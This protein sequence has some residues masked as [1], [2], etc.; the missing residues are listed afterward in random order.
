MAGLAAVFSILGYG[1]AWGSGLAAAFLFPG[2]LALAVL[3][4]LG[5]DRLLI[6]SRDPR[7]PFVWVPILGVLVLTGLVFASSGA[8][9]RG[10]IL[11]ILVVLLPTLILRV[12]WVN[13]GAAV[14]LSLLLFMD[15]AIANRNVYQHPFTDAP[16]VYRQHALGLKAA[17]EQSLDGRVL[18]SA[19]PLNAG[20]TRNLGMVTALN[21]AGGAGLPLTREQGQWWRR[22]AGPEHQEIPSAQVAPEAAAP[23]LLNFMAVQVIAAGEDSPLRRT[24]WMW[25]RP[26]LRQARSADAL[27]LYAN[28][29]ALRRAHWV[30][31]WHRAPTFDAALDLLADP[32]LDHRSTAILT[33]SGAVPPELSAVPL[34]DEWT[35]PADG[36]E[37][38]CTITEDSPESVVLRVRAEAAGIVVLA[39]TDAPGWRAYLNGR[40]VPI[41]RANGLFRGVA[42]P[43]GE[44]DL[45]FVYRPA[46][47]LAGIAVGTVTLAVLLLIGLAGLVRPALGR[48]NRRL[49]G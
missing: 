45:V 42:V 18:I 1:A 40:R 26:R 3:A 12:R 36:L 4:G 6:A 2:A 16:A 23:V 11:I 30:P 47:V 33:V 32:A 39:D 24:G 37:G 14:L 13:F 21:V 9:A 46:P 41:H 19:H 8:E 35:P 38:V 20:L 25:E 15:L 44:H 17:E 34:R 49:R 22:L 5:A 28:D 27:T 29:D 7:S 31:S 48:R 10:R 43:E